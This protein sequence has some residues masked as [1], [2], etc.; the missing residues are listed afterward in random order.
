MWSTELYVLRR[1][2]DDAP[3]AHAGLASRGKHQVV[4]SRS[5]HGLL[6]KDLPHSH[7][8]NWNDHCQVLLS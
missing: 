7:S 5:R 2:R 4:V 3:R 6:L 1:E 8:E